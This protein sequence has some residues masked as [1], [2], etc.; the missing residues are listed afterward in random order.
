MECPLVTKFAVVR[1]T[2]PHFKLVWL[3]S[4]IHFLYTQFLLLFTVKL[5]VAAD[6]PSTGEQ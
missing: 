5:A 3:A 1:L 2:I 6:L 4:Q